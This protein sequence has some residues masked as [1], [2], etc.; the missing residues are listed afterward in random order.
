MNNIY[1][2]KFSPRLSLKFTYIYKYKI[3][4]NIKYL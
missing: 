2:I 3:N 1:I 4:I